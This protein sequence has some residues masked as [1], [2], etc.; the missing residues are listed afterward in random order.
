[1]Q[2]NFNWKTY[3]CR[4]LQYYSLMYATVIEIER[5]GVCDPLHYRNFISEEKE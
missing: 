5:A 2:S 4:F 1:M 3:L